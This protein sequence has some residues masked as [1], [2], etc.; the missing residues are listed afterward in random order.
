MKHLMT[1]IIVVGKSTDKVSN[2]NL[3]KEIDKIMKRMKCDDEKLQK[4]AYVLWE[5]ERGKLMEDIPVHLHGY[6]K[7]LRTLGY[8]I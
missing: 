4:F 7:V 2:K 3:R 6:R 1:D 5:E 8:V